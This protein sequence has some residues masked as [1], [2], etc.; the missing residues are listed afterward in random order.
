MQN[1][2]A[3]I[4]ELRASIQAG[5]QWLAGV[6]VSAANPIRPGEIGHHH[7]E[8]TGAVRGEYSSVEKQW[9]FFCPLWHTGQAVRAWVMASR[10]GA[11]DWTAQ[12]RSG[13]DF[14]LKNQRE[15]GLILAYED[16]PDKVNTSAIL[17]GLSG[18]FALADFS[19]DRR[20][21]SAALKAVDWVADHAFQPGEGLFS[22]LYDPVDER[23]I[24]RGYLVKG[25]PLADDAIFFE[26]Y[27]RTGGKRYLE[28]ALAVLERL[29]R[30]ERPAGN[31]IDYP[32]C[33]PHLDRIHPRHAFW[34]GR[35]FLTAFKVTGEGRYFA[36]FKRAMEWYRHALRTDG[37]LFRDTSQH[38]N[39]ASFRHTTSA[40]ACAALMFM[41]YWRET[42]DESI[43][44]PLAN[45]LR[46]CLSMQIRETRE[47]RL[48]GAVIESVMNP[49]GTD[50]APIVIRDLGTIFL[51]QAA[52]EF[53]A[54]F[55]QAPD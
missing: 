31:W 35:P 54:A 45:A 20:Y 11:G 18:L 53:I 21:E 47:P 41:D 9:R 3:M 40:S 5:C 28:I 30:D 37:G 51:V 55:G 15:D 25:R 43:M 14:L 24:P 1:A 48:K 27:R 46:F 10:Q 13:A 16:H 6:Q 52:C 34:W 39:T 38:G 49:Q 19:D 33:M 44:A 7:E 2:T 4:S 22:D 23:F 8:W 17:E 36:A 42:G 32:P 29:L 26:A 50:H 12:A